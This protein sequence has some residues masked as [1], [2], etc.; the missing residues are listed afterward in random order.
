[1]PIS[2]LLPFQVLTLSGTPLN[3]GCEKPFIRWVRQHM[4]PGAGPETN[5]GLE[6]LAF[7]RNRKHDVENRISVPWDEGCTSLGS[8]V[9]FSPMQYLE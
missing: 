7:I 5:W 6:K 2:K 8:R 9:F 1:M 3:L 4:P